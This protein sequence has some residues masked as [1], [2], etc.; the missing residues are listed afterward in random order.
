[1]K[2]CNTYSTSSSKLK[3][4]DS[5]RLVLALI[6]K[7]TEFFQII[8]W[9]KNH[10]ADYEDRLGAMLEQISQKAPNLK[11]FRVKSTFLF[12]L[13]LTKPCL[14]FASKMTSV[15]TLVITAEWVFSD[16]DLQILVET[17]PNVQ[18]L[19]VSYK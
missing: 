16:D 15:Q 10:W 11:S 9:E 12:D 13:T 19:T 6:N 1:M 5:H 17:F 14:E 18:S 2:F 4:K 7:D 8:K 3:P